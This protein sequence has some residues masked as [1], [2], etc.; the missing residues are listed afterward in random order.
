MRYC[1][2][3]A[4]FWYVGCGGSAEVSQ[5]SNQTQGQVDDC[6]DCYQFLTEAEILDGELEDQTS[7]EDCLAVL[8]CRRE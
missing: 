1:F 5:E 6:G 3:A 7:L 8:D 4:M 2:I